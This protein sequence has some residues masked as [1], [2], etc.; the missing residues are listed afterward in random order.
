MCR[1]MTEKFQDQL[2][3]GWENAGLNWRLTECQE[4]WKDLDYVTA[5]DKITITVQYKIKIIVHNKITTV[6]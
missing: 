1:K 6:A 4:I 3:Q 5:Q 2:K